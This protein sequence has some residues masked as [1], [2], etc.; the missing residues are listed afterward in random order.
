MWE[1]ILPGCSGK[2]VLIVSPDLKDMGMTTQ[3]RWNFTL[4]DTMGETIRDELSR[5]G[6]PMRSSEYEL[7]CPI[8]GW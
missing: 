2:E 1:I 3:A 6:S 4:N 5:L 8:I 7:G